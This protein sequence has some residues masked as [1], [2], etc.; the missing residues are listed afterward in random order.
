MDPFELEEQSD[1]KSKSNWFSET[2]IKLLTA[3]L[4]LIAVVLNLFGR[5][6]KAVWI[7]GSLAGV[8][9]SWAICSWMLSLLRRF[10]R[11]RGNRRYVAKEYQ[12][13]LRMFERLEMFMSREDTRSFRYL[14]HNASSYR[15]DAIDQICASDYLE[16]W[17][18]CFK[19]ILGNPCHSV[20]E[21]LA[22]C[23]EFTTIVTNFNKDYV[24]KIQ[25]GIEKNTTL[26]ESYIDNFELFRER[27]GLYLHELEQ[28]LETVTKETATRVSHQEFCQCV[29]H[30]SF[31]RV[32]SFLKGRT[33]STRA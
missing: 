30:R 5:S 23:R 33:V 28:W 9:L 31:E 15:V 27:F 2:N 12:N 3:V 8:L 19:L 4:A 29:P 14:L 17:M 16:G 21:F 13:L 24:M 10:G 11:W 22:R 7:L 25:P 32:K 18:N 1:T 20:T 6:P 26:P